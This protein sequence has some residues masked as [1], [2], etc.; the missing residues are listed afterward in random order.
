VAVPFCF[1]F[2]TDSVDAFGSSLS[3]FFSETA[4]ICFNCLTVSV[5][6]SDEVSMGASISICFPSAAIAFREP[7]REELDDFSDLSLPVLGDLLL[8]G[9]F[10]DLLLATIGD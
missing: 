1:T 7:S 6:G 9:D 5:G 3:T 2:F 8:R 10:G 4:S